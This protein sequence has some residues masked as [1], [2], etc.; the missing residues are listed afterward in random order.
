MTFPEF[1]FPSFPSFSP[2]LSVQYA[3]WLQD[4]RPRTCLLVQWLAAM[5]AVPHPGEA[6]AR[7]AQRFASKRAL[8]GEIVDRST[9]PTPVRIA[10]LI[11]DD[12]F[13]LYVTYLM[14]LRF[15]EYVPARFVLPGGTEQVL[16]W[17]R[18]QLRRP[19]LNDSETLDEL[20]WH[21]R[22]IGEFWEEEWEISSHS[23]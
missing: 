23:D 4:L 3:L 18:A 21:A 22:R 20:L 2:N 9:G 19:E 1:P 13:D 7:K 17:V 12:D 6:T 14:W 11:E 10:R 16:K 15:R 5:G 8:L